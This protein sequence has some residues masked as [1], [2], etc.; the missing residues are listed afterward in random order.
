MVAVHWP[1]EIVWHGFEIGNVL[2][3]GRQL[4]QTPGDN[5]VRKAYELRPYAGRKAIERG[6]PSYDQ[7]A[8]LFAVR[9]AEPEY[10]RLVGGGRVQVD[11]DGQTTWQADSGGQHAFVKLVGAPE[12]LA[13][14]IE[15]LMIA[16]P[17][18]P[19]STSAP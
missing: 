17:M 4:K 11:A 13:A 9:G 16:A 19:K 8:A 2:I 12:R 14:V 6:Q 1:G 7:A 3:T 10:W 18:N 5:P 15:S